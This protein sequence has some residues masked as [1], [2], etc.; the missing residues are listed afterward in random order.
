M[1][2]NPALIWHNADIRPAQSRTDYAI[3]EGD[4]PTG[5][6]GGPDSLAEGDDP[7]FAWTNV[8][9]ATGVS[10]LRSTVRMADIADGTSHTYLIG[11]KHVSSAHYADAADPGYDQ[12]PFTGVDLDLNRWTYFTPIRDDPRIDPRSFGSA[13]AGGCHMSFCDG[14]VRVVS[15]NI[16]AFIHRQLGNRRDGGP[17]GWE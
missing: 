4:F 17:H 15:Y 2:N 11:E 12:S 10:F 6:D 14:S 16:D 3:N 1:P 5:T 7:G 13:H 8:T 9:G